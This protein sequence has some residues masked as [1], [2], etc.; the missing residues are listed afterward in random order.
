MEFGRV[1]Q[2]GEFKMAPTSDNMLYS[3]RHGWDA[4]E[5]RTR[6]RLAAEKVGRTS[7]KAAQRNAE[8]VPTG[9]VEASPGVGEQVLR[10]VTRAEAAKAGKHPLS[11]PQNAQQSDSDSSEEDSGSSSGSSDDDEESYENEPTNILE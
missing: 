6:A 3:K 5:E 2:V 4:L 7:K 8:A 10:V 1:H 11:H 9:D